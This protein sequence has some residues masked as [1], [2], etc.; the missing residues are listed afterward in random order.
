MQVNYDSTRPTKRT[1]EKRRCLLRFLKVFILAMYP[2]A[3]LKLYGSTACGLDD[4]SSDLDVGLTIPE[5]R[6]EEDARVLRR[7]MQTLQSHQGL[8]LEVVFEANR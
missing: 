6:R 8:N 1:Q 2:G 3:Q 4:D 7:I 5:H